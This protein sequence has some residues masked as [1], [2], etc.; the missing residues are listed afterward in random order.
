MRSGWAA[1][2]LA[3]VCVAS[4]ALS[5]LAC[6]LAFP[7]SGLER[8]SDDDGGFE[9]DVREGSLLDVPPGD[10]GGGEARMADAADGIGS[11]ITVVQTQSSVDDGGTSLSIDVA[12]IQAG[13]FVAVLVTYAFGDAT[14]EN[15]VGVSDDGP[16]G[17]NTYVS[18]NLQSVVPPCQGSEIWYARNTTAGA[19]TITVTVSGTAPIQLWVIEASGLRA[20]GGVDQGATGSGGATTSIQAPVVTPTGVPALIVS[21]AGSCG[22][23]SG[24]DNSSPF[25]G[26]TAQD[27]NDAAYYVA[28]TPGSYGPIYGNTDD[29]WN[30]S[31]AAFR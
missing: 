7:I 29:D 11:M 21:A 23:I 16:A 13:D 22:A 8:A 27:G 2:A 18:A 24:V 14:S 6:E 31:V 20:T 3:L 19:T 15:V 17:G 28:T 26:L 12:P 25:T 4:T 1:T 10:G 5:L 30:A 9:G